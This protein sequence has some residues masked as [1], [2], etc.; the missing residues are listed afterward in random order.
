MVVLEY[1]ELANIAP[2]STSEKDILKDLISDLASC[3]CEGNFL[4]PN[5]AA[6]LYSALVHVDS[7]AYDDAGQLVV[8]AR[9]LLGS[10]PREPKLTKKTFAKHEAT[11]LAL[12]QTFFLLR[13]AN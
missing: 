5:F 7:F 8:V 13:E 4:P 2:Y 1:A 10:L 9:K 11:F 12:Q 3:I 6:A